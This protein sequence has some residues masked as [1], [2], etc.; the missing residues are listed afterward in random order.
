[1]SLESEMDQPDEVFDRA[2]KLV[3][4]AAL[5]TPRLVGSR[6]EATMGSCSR[7]RERRRSQVASTAASPGFV[8]FDAELVQMTVGA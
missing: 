5:R 3:D 7:A 8:E 4:A 6:A 1:V 2:Q